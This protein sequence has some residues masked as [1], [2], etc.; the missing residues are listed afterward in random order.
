MAEIINFPQNIELSNNTQVAAKIH[1]VETAINNLD[2]QSGPLLDHMS[3]VN[4]DPEI[5]PKLNEHYQTEEI[6][7]FS[8]IFIP[9]KT[10]RISGRATNNPSVFFIEI[11]DP[12]DN[13]DYGFGV[14]KTDLKQ[15]A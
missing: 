13:I 2:D 11:Q 14:T 1:E 9:E 12:A 4:T 10:T 7:D 6:I 5:T 3:F 15:A 8:N